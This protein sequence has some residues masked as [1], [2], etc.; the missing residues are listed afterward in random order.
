MKYPELMTHQELI[1][2]FSKKKK[3]KK[4]NRNHFFMV[5]FLNN[6]IPC[7]SWFMAGH[8]LHNWL[9]ILFGLKIWFVWDRESQ[10]PLPNNTS[11]RGQTSI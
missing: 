2:I 6:T 7:W 1:E 9:V 10:Q 4:D 11:S 3:K 5:T 8:E